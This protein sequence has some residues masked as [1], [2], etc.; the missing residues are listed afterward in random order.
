MFCAVPGLIIAKMSENSEG[1]PNSLAAAK[2]EP[3]RELGLGNG[4]MASRSPSDFSDRASATSRAS[5]GSG[6]VAGMSEG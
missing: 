6:V 5:A 2:M 4:E 3:C 1:T